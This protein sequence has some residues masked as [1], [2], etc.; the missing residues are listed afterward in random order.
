MVMKNLFKGENIFFELY[1][2]MD[3]EHSTFKTKIVFLNSFEGKKS[4]AKNIV[5]YLNP[6]TFLENRIFLTEK[7]LL[8][9]FNRFYIAPLD[10]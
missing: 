8:T 5:N 2:N 9:D 7:S 10:I 3:V 6:C 1:Q 4:V